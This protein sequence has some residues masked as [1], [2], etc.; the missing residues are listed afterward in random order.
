MD[1]PFFQS[2]RKPAPA[3]HQTLAK[4][5]QLVPHREAP[6]LWVCGRLRRLSLSHTRRHPIEVGRVVKRSYELAHA[7]NSD[8]LFRP[9]CSRGAGEH[10]FSSQSLLDTPSV[11]FTPTTQPRPLVY[12]LVFF[13]PPSV[14]PPF[15]LSLS[16]RILAVK[17][18]V[19]SDIPKTPL[20]ATPPRL[21]TSTNHQ[22]PC[23]SSL[24]SPSSSRRTRVR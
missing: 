24:P 11:C 2:E 10:C 6:S 19:D 8:R 4:R 16:F 14:L 17:I 20:V 21:R 1:V 13:P 23:L 22:P 7:S 15:S 5:W 18:E 12:S 3:R 9:T